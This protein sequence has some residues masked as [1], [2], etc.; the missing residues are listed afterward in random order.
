M[1]FCDLVRSRRSVR[2][3][4]D[5]PVDEQ[6]LH[7]IMEAGMYA[8]SAVNFQPWYF[9]VIQSA[10]QRERLGRVMEQVSRN[11]EPSLKARFA[12]HPHVAEETVQFIRCLG[13][14]PV[15]I[16]AFWHKTEYPKKESSIIQS[17]SAAIE[18][19]LLAAADK[20]LG[21]CWMTSPLEANAE[22][23]IRAM[24]APEHGDLVAAIALGYPKHIPA[25]PP[26]KEGRYTVI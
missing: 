16:L 23:E 22:E 8:P 14:A 13:G 18:N 19:I 7:E 9:V 12:N 15:C 11:M 20:G 26:R 2:S 1:E 6:I 3:Y 5:K 25:P 10:E 24:F 4:L 21:A 17:I